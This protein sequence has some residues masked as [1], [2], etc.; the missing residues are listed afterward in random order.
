MIHIL[1]YYVTPFITGIIITGI[2]MS[3]HWMWLGFVT[4]CFIMIGGDSLLGDDETTPHY[5]QYWLVE[6]PLHL[7]LPFIGLLLISLAWSSGKGEY[8]FLNIGEFL[9]QYFSYSF[10]EYRNENTNLDYLGA[11]LGVGFMVAGYGTNVGHE[12]THRIKNKIAM[13][14]GRWLLSASCNADF[15]IEHVYG[16]HVTVGTDKDPATAH[17]C[18]N[19]YSFFV[20]STLYGHI[21][22]WRLEYVRLKKK[23]KFLF[24]FHNQMLTGY[25]MSLCIAY[26]FYVA[27]GELGLMLFFAQALLAKFILEIVNYMEHYGLKRNPDQPVGPEHSWNTN[28]RMSSIILFSLTRHSAH[29]ENPRVPFWK[30][31]PYPKAPQMPYGY[32]TTLFLCLIPPVWKKI[33][34]K[35]LENWEHQYGIE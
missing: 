13:F 4:L 7:A 34:S 11:V 31:D 20:R 2:F 32:L 19:V 23:N 18:E 27:G 14:E 26:I 24:S 8:D 12:L 9:S 1:K 22:A 3:G 33:I 21:N 28:R 17:K 6:L 15:S 29:H 16:H 10:I 30:L 5:S 35:P 25:A